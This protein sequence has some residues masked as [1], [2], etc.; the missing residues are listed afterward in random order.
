MLHVSI[1]GKLK[2]RVYAEAAINTHLQLASAAAIGFDGH[3]CAPDHR[4]RPFVRRC[5]RAGSV[6]RRYSGKF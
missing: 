2:M 6:N 4:R 3:S 5:H 1:G